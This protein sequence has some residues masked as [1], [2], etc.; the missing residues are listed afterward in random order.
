MN[1]VDS[2]IYDIDDNGEVSV[3][4]GIFQKGKPLLYKK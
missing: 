4:A 3:E 2:I 1:E